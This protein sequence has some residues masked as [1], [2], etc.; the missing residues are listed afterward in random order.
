MATAPDQL[1]DATTDPFGDLPD[2]PPPTIT[3]PTTPVVP[4][5]SDE[6]AAQNFATQ[7]KVASQP[8]PP[9]VVPTPFDDLPDVPVSKQP[10]KTPSVAVQYDENPFGEIGVVGAGLT[11]EGNMLKGTLA[12]IGVGLGDPDRADT[13]ENLKAAVNDQPLPIDQEE[14]VLPTPLRVAAKVSQDLV[15]S[16]PQLTLPFGVLPKAAQTALAV[17][18]TAYTLAQVPEIGNELLKQYSL[19]PDQ[20]DPKT[21]SDLWSDALETVG[22]TALGAA[23]SLHGVAKDVP[24]INNLLTKTVINSYPP[25]VL[26]DIFVRVKNDQAYQTAVDEDGA[27]PRPQQST[28]EEKNLYDLIQSNIG[29]KPAIK[30]DTGVSV[31][32]TT[33]RLTQDWLNKYLGVDTTPKRSLSFQRDV[34]D[35]AAPGAQPVPQPVQQLTQGDQSEIPQRETETGVPTATGQG[36]GQTPAAAEVPQT[37]IIPAVKLSDVQ[38]Q[39]GT[40]VPVVAPTKPPLQIIKSVL[41]MTP[42]QLG[43]S[44]PMG[45]NNLTSSAWRLGQMIK[46]PQQL[47]ALQTAAQSAPT[48]FHR[49]FFNEAVGAATGTGSAGLALSKEQPG[50]KPPFPQSA[51]PTAPV[52][53]PVAAPVPQGDFATLMQANGYKT[54]EDMRVDHLKPEK[55]GGHVAE[56]GETEE[57]FMR[58]KY[59]DQSPMKRA[60]ET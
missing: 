1:P 35:E 5:S 6:L 38:P 17:G 56:V 47:T 39:G 26:K 22:F 7:Q 53:P 15:S 44:F 3:I 29:E 59:C 10:D 51:P 19:P 48:A 2:A 11:R 24:I 46:T 54:V 60:L 21:T 13:W 30:S 28:P 33:P 49:Q 45:E 50:Y 34:P 23:G 57:E 52:A 36:E 8:P 37:Q 41:A 16:A 4:Q 14:T 40:V 18:F 12:D 32:D 58:R 31:S 43:A 9:T 42:A 25:D 20:R 27:T 55:E